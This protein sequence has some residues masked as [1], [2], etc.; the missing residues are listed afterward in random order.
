VLTGDWCVVYRIIHSRISSN[1][2]APTSLRS[3]IRMMSKPVGGRSIS[4]IA[5]YLETE[6][7]LDETSHDEDGFVDSC[8]VAVTHRPS[9]YIGSAAGRHHGVNNMHIMCDISVGDVGFHLWR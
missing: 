6:T 1:A 3:A 9:E 5:C 7:L 8:E 4:D 2:F